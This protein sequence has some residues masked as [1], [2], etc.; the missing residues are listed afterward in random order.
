M[1]NRLPI[2]FQ[3]GALVVLWIVL[4][5]VDNWAHWELKKAESVPRG[6][7]H[8]LFVF[9]AG[10]AIIIL[11]LSVRF[12]WTFVRTQRRK[13][14]IE[15]IIFAVVVVISILGFVSLVGSC[16]SMSLGIVLRQIAEEI[17]RRL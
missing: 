16:G 12:G 5:W 4:F 14:A 17:I 6:G 13:Q 9:V 7:M 2:W 11:A 8:R 10:I 3:G 15:L 1:S